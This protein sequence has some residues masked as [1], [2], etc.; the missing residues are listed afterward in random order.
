MRMMASN[1]GY[2]EYV[3][4]LNDGDYLVDFKVNTVG[5]QDIIPSNRN[6][7]ELKWS[8]NLPS[9]EKSI[10]NERMYST[11]YF[12]YLNDEVDYLSET[13]NDE[14]NLEGKAHWIGL[15]HQFFSSVIINNDGFE[16]PTFVKTTTN[17]M[18]TRFVK[19]LE[20][21]T[22]L[23]YNHNYK[24]SI[25][26]KIYLGPNHYETL[27]SYNLNLERMIPRVGVYLDG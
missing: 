5:L 13:K 4:K 16:K 20:L 17:E 15:K 21:E 3:Y 11:V 9:T 12:K 8:I 23:A 18:S 19:N 22:Q 1:G 10:E 26:L 24:E 7:L 6:D 14:E 2:L 25:P 27:S